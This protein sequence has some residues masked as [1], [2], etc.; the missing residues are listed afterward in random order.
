MEVF[1]AHEDSRALR[2]EFF[3]DEVER[4]VTVDPLTGAG[5]NEITR[6]V[7]YPGSH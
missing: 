2:I 3:G 5:I 4:I 7:I 6:A 1:P